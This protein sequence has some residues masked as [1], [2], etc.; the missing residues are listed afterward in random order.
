MRRWRGRRRG[1]GRRRR[2][3]GKRDII[4]GNSRSSRKISESRIGMF[5]RTRSTEV[6]TRYLKIVKIFN[7]ERRRMFRRMEKSIIAK[8]KRRW[9]QDNST[10][11]E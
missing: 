2:R 7:S 10:T 9:R 4:G 1:R 3:R 11:S 6:R 8:V 5:R